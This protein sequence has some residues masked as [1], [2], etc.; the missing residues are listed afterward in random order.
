MASVDAEAG[1]PGLA[2]GGIRYAAHVI[3]SSA[4]SAGATVPPGLVTDRFMSGHHLGKF[5]SLCFL[6]SPPTG[7]VSS[8]ALR[9]SE[10]SVSSG[11]ISAQ[12]DRNSRRVTAPFVMRSMAT[13]RA[14]GGGAFSVT[15]WLISPWV[16]PNFPAKVFWSVLER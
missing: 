1:R 2:D 5:A 12:S 15:H 16:T 6:R 10:S 11:Q 8:A 13:H 14:G 9:P 3:C 4:E 7:W